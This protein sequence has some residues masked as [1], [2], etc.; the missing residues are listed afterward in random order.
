MSKEA[1]LSPSIL[2]LAQKVLSVLTMTEN[3]NQASTP[4]LPSKIAGFFG[5]KLF[6][7]MR[8]TLSV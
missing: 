5:Q 6:L 2:F 3:I 7:V 4:F 8:K 1:V